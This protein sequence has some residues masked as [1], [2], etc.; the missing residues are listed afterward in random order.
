MPFKH[1]LMGRPKR[2]RTIKAF[3]VPRLREGGQEDAGKTELG[4]L[5]LL[6]PVEG[7]PERKQ[8]AITKYVSFCKQPF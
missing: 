1:A 3:T 7:Y 4:E 6:S 5:G 8:C 2:A